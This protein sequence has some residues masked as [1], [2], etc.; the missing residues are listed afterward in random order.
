MPQL[1]CG[2]R[3]CR[4][5]GACFDKGDNHKDTHS[6]L[7]T[8]E[9]GEGQVPIFKTFQD[10]PQFLERPI[11][12]KGLSKLLKQRI[13]DNCKCTNRKLGMQ[14]WKCAS[15]TAKAWQKHFFP[16]SSFPGFFPCKHF[17]VFAGCL[18]PHLL[19]GK[20]RVRIRNSVCAR[21]TFWSGSSF[22]HPQLKRKSGKR[23]ETKHTRGARKHT[24]ALEMRQHILT[25]FTP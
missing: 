24:V 23:L 4:F 15:L 12:E 3:V 5:E 6:M 22:L 9:R 2:M 20:V 19:G 25:F 21:Q 18:E 13:P 14:F 16:C 11:G 8:G 7:G 17:R 1:S 10:T